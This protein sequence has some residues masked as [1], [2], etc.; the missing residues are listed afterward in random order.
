MKRLG[1]HLKNVLGHQQNNQKAGCICAHR[2]SNAKVIMYR[3]LSEMHTANLVTYHPPPFP[4]PPTTEMKKRIPMKLKKRPIADSR[5][6][7]SWA[8]LWSAS[9]ADAPAVLSI[10]HE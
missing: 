5:V 8:L 7:A 6:I 9:R 10:L 3:L 4:M 1:T 2:F